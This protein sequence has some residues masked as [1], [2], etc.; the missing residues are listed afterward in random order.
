MNTKNINPNES[1]QTRPT[2]LTRLLFSL[3]HDC[4]WA[5]SVNSPR[6]LSQKY[7]IDHNKIQDFPRL[8]YKIQG[9]QG[10]EFGPIKFKA[11]QDFQGPVWTE[12][13][14]HGLT[15]RPVHPSFGR[16]KFESYVF[17][18]AVIC[19]GRVRQTGPSMS[20]FCASLPVHAIL[21]C[22]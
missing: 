22:H 16:A 5:M 15:Q 7:F 10:L 1:H 20:I 8:L 9:F 12:Y 2:D 21:Q 19:H 4:H 17:G 14:T 3:P 13:K 18:R 11:F 6:Q